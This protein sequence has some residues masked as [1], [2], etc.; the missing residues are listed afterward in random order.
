MLGHIRIGTD[1]EQLLGSL[2]ELRSYLAKSAGNL[3][4]VLAFQFFHQDCQ[5]GGVF[6]INKAMPGNR[7]LNEGQIFHGIDGFTP[8]TGPHGEWATIS[9]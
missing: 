2:R 5:I 6:G 3:V 4:R 8:S 9:V 1:A 7:A